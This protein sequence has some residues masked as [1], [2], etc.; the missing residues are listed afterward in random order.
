M[1]K[2]WFAAIISIPVLITAY[3]KFIPIVRDWTHG[4]AAP[5]LGRVRRC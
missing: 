5:G 2:F 3:P 1:S 4:D